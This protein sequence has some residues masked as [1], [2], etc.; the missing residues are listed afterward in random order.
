MTPEQLQK[1]QKLAENKMP[2]AEGFFFGSQD[3][4][5]Y[6]FETLRETKE[7]IENSLSS[8]PEDEYYYSSSW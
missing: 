4:D 8:T 2:A 5:E 1:V 7:A 3:Y 6:Y